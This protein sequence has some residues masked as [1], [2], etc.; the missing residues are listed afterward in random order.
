MNFGPI[1]QF[2]ISNF[3]TIYLTIYKLTNANFMTKMTARQLWKRQYQ[4]QVGNFG[5]Y[6]C[7]RMLTEP[8]SEPQNQVAQRQWNT[9]Y[10]W[11]SQD[12]R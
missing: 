3:M 9:L 4:I 2:H 10:Y 6:L 8:H 1:F 5:F 11:S 12:P 7:Y